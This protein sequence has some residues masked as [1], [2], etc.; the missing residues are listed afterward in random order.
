MP[1]STFTTYV[2]LPPMA[3]ISGGLAVLLQVA[4]HLDRGGFPVRVVRREGGRPALPEWFQVPVMEW[5]RLQLD[6]D[7]VWL[8]PE[9]WANAL[10]PGLRAGAK[11]VVYVQNWAYLFSSLPQGVSWRDLAVSFLAVSRPVSWFIEQ[12]LGRSSLVVRPGINRSLFRPPDRKPDGPLRVAFMPRKNKALADLIRDLFSAR[13]PEFGLADQ[14]IWIDIQGR[15]HAEVAELLTHSHIFLATGFPEGFSL[16]P[17]EA[18]ACGCLPV[19]F[20]GFGGWEYMT[21][22]NEEGGGDQE[23]WRPWFPVPENPWPGNGFWVPDADAMAAVLALEQAARLLRNQGPKLEQ[24]LH[25]GQLTA[26][27]FALE[28]Q[29]EQVLAVWPKITSSKAWARLT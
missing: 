28:A 10:A 5:G 19:G 22:I 4:E 23:P 24:A 6:G 9:G 11:C 20:A 29:R 21:P 3:K 13:N 26:D 15:S 7:D 27:A 18:M 25:A 1:P 12:A 16:P 14:M 8:V 2:F 17:L